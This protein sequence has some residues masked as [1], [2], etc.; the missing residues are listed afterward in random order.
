MSRIVTP[1]LKQKWADISKQLM[2]P[3]KRES[4]EFLNSVVTE[5]EGW[6]HHFEAEN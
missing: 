6:V 4:D 3:Y 5:N 2:L 1:K